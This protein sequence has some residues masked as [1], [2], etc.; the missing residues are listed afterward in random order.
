MIQYYV[1]GIIHNVAIGT[2]SCITN[3]S[4]ATVGMN[5]NCTES[6]TGVTSITDSVAELTTTDE[7]EA[8]TSDS[9]R[10]LIVIHSKL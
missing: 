9:K 10:C 7:V 8:D 5:G 4:M 6:S 3:S 2:D 1:A